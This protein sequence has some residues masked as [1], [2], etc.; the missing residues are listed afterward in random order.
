MPLRDPDGKKY[1]GLFDEWLEDL[2]D[3]GEEPPEEV[4]E[5]PVDIEEGE[6]VEEPAEGEAEALDIPSGEVKVVGTRDPETGMR[7]VVMEKLPEKSP[8]VPAVR[9]RHVGAKALALLSRM[10]LVGLKQLSSS[11]EFVVYDNQ[12]PPPGEYAVQALGITTIEYDGVKQNHLLVT[13]KAGQITGFGVED[14]YLS[15]EALY[16]A[17]V[18]DEPIDI[19]TLLGVRNART[20][21]LFTNRDIKIRFNSEFDPSISISANQCPFVIDLGLNIEWLFL[22]TLKANT[23][24]KLIGW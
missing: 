14:T 9:G 6:P 18:T 7:P 22:S 19:Q 4:E 1:D 10:P 8:E 2:F 16:A 20:V 21:A 13:F 23:K 3:S 11:Q 12:P 24:V 5:E 17:I 15:H